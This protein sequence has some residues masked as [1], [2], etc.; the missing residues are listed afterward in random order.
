MS[1]EASGED[2]DVLQT[3]ADEIAAEIKS[4]PGLVD[5]AQDMEKAMPELQFRVNRQRAAMLNL[6]TAAVGQYLRTAVNGMEVS[7]FRAG[8]DEYDI[9]VRLREGQRRSVDLLKQVSMTTKDGDRVPL[10]SL[11][12]FAYE[13]GR[14]QILRKDQKRVITITGNSQGRGSDK[15]LADVRARVSSMRLPKGYEVSYTGENK[16]MMEAFVFLRKAFMIAL[17]LIALILVME[18]NSVFQPLMVMISVILS[19]IG[20]M[21]ALMLCGMRFG[22]IMTGIGVISLAGVVV[23]NGIVLI[24]YINQRKAGGLATTDAIV[25][26]G[27][28]RLRPVLLTAITTVVG[29]IP[30][31]IGWSVEFHAFPPHIVRSAET[32]AWWAPM[33][34]AV[35]FGL[36]LAT[37][38]TLLQVPVMYSLADSFVRRLRGRAQT[39]G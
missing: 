5:V 16:D 25:T 28:L 11:G 9:T 32:S 27:A 13:G 35:I 31:A 1:I 14:G 34:V 22:V 38:L 15:V 7:K 18:F 21:W 23:N 8:E 29:L 19:M 33:A 37:V 6:D 20:V 4:V 24:D 36:T 26:A 30:M 17:A 39:N 2:F 3:V 10:A 12:A